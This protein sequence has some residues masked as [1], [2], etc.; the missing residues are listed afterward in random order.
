MDIQLQSAAGQIERL[1]RFDQCAHE[2][3]DVVI[4]VKRGRRNSQTFRAAR[5]GGIVDGLNVDAVTL[6]QAVGGRL[7]SFRIANHQGHDMSGSGEHRQ[8]GVDQRVL[9]LGHL[10]LLTLAFGA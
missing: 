6:Q 10:A 3:G 7:T 2:L 1:P 5:Y 9:E 8:V 4:G